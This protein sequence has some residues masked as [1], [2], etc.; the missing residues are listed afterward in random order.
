MRE[1]GFHF[2]MQMQSVSTVYHVQ[3]AAGSASNCTSIK[4]QLYAG[5]LPML[6]MIVLEVFIA[7]SAIA[8]AEM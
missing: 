7:F 5:V 3:C 4:A 1:H 6:G 2:E 8:R